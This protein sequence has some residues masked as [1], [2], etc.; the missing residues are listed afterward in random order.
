MREKERQQ[1]N[2]KQDWQK[3]DA[4]ILGQLLV[5]QNILFV[6]HDEARIAEYFSQALSSVPG[7]I[8]CFV[9]LGNLTAPP[10]FAQEV[11]SGCTALRKNEYGSLPMPDNFSCGLAAKQGMRAIPLQTNEHAF[12]LFIFQTDSTTAFEPYWP[13]LSNLANY[14]A[15][16]LETRIQKRS[17]E[18]SRDELEM[19]VKERTEE[20]WRMN[21]ELEQRVKQRTAELEER[22]A[23]L[24]KMNRL[25]VGRE[26]R[27]VELKEKIRELE[28][29]SLTTNY[30]VDPDDY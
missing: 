17:L 2:P 9:C 1:D 14:V 18:K 8:S 29:K 12:G 7:V 10:R 21:T 25:F 27:M 15:L 11:C 20:L 22:N 5:A 30:A 13:F 23:E 26:L 16:T 28:G 19:R 6:L 24:H 3:A 4:R